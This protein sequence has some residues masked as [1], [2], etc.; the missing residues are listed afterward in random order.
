MSW[1]RDEQDNLINLDHIATIEV[2]EVE[3][4]EEHAVLALKLN[5]EQVILQR[6]TEEQCRN[7]RERIWGKLPKMVL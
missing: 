6:G 3:G 7:F 2:V 5:D 4:C 1:F